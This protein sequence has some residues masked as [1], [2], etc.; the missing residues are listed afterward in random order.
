MTPSLPGQQGDETNDGRITG[1]DNDEDAANKED[2]L[3]ENRTG[4]TQVLN[5]GIKA[6]PNSLNICN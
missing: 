3:F 6:V 4:V 1:N 5:R 2:T